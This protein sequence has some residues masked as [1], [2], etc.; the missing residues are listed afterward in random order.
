MRGRAVPAADI[1]TPNHFELEQLTGRTVRTPGGG[2]GGRRC[3]A[4]AR[5]EVVLVTSLLTDE[6]PAD[7]IDLVA[8]DEA[9]RHRL[10]TPKL[11]VAA[12]GAG[13]AIA[14]LFLAHYLRAGSA[15]RGD[16]AG[17]GLDLRHPQAHRGRGRRRNGAD[18]GAG[19]AGE[20]P[21]DELSRRTIV[22]T[23][24]PARRF[25]RLR[26]D[27]VQ[28]S[29]GR[30]GIRN[31]RPPRSQPLRRWRIITKSGSRSSSCS[32]ARAFTPTTSPSTTRRRSA[33]RRRRACSWRRS[34]SA[35]RGCAS[36][37]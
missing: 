4:R 6:T 17:G 30:D 18:R 34:R 14:A 11:P 21:S 32:T 26:G 1:V 27:D 28:C 36:G 29:V 13:D 35:P 20:S 15:A 19:R 3:L 24:M 33:W 7:A 2:A 31:L 16:V 22:R 9:G 10:R 8:C 12:H 23:R 37:R 25:C 5:P